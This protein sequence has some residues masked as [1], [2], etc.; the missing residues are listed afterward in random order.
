MALAAVSA[1][2][3]NLDKWSNITMNA[4]DLRP[5]AKELEDAR[6]QLRSL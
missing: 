5:R 6:F 3:E 1:G 2:Q 4:N